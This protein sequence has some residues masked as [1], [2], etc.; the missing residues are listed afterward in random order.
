MFTKPFLGKMSKAHASSIANQTHSIDNSYI[1]RLIPYLT[2]L[3]YG[4]YRAKADG[5]PESVIPPVRL[6]SADGGS[7][8]NGHL[9]FAIGSFIKPII[10]TALGLIIEDSIER[11]K[12]PA[13]IA[14]I[15]N[16]AWTQPAF[17]VWN[18][19]RSVR[20]ELK[21]KEDPGM[22]PRPRI[23]GP[24]RRNPSLRE[25]VLHI[26]ACPTNPR[27][28]FGP[29]GKFVMSDGV[30]E[31]YIGPLIDG[32]AEAQESSDSD[33]LMTYSNWNYLV[34]GK[35]VAEAMGTSLAEALK[36]LVFKRLG[37]EHTVVDIPGFQAHEDEM[38]EARIETADAEGCRRIDR[39]CY[40][41]DDAELS[42]G[43]GYSCVEDIAKLLNFLWG[44]RDEEGWSDFIQ[45]EFVFDGF[46]EYGTTVLGNWQGVDTQVLRMQSYDRDFGPK[47]YQLGPSK[48][49]SGRAVYVKAGAVMGYSC[50]YF[51]IPVESLFIIVLTNS[52]GIVDI[53][54][55]VGQYI[56]KQL[57]ETERAIDFADVVRQIRDDRR[58]YLRR[59]T[60]VPPNV[61]PFS[62]EDLDTLKGCYEQQAAVPPSPEQ[63]PS[64]ER[65]IVKKVGQKAKAWIQMSANDTKQ[66]GPLDIVKVADDTLALRAEP[67]KSTI[68]GYGDWL[69]VEL[70]MHKR[71]G[72]ISALEM[73]ADPLSSELKMYWRVCID[74]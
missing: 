22:I 46:F 25:A 49:E 6:P 66:N 17:S 4:I 44:R 32:T 65:I 62:E 34:A 19:L 48:S 41:H 3:V 16:G 1:T 51:V 30:V 23:N 18:A 9:L 67:R 8:D 15:M 21:K 31:W 43:G 63:K 35:V 2:C 20:D 73:L 69:G 33:R 57:L 74:I 56:L 26:N 71:D 72:K 37:M 39:P 24:T 40:L 14:E 36:V 45:K 52:S 5:S 64:G 11:N 47:S 53:S 61:Q 50:H 27:Q 55:H 13:G 29:Q 42:T 10:F 28:L 68:D 54:N 38:A 70:K 58:E 7:V 12:L 60:D 59:R